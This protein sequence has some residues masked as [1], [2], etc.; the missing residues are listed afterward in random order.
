MQGHKT[1]G[2][3]VVGKAAAEIVKV[4]PQKDTHSAAI[5]RLQ[6]SPDLSN[7]SR[8]SNYLYWLKTIAADRPGLSE[9][10]LIPN[11][12]YQQL[13]RQSLLIA[14]FVSRPQSSVIT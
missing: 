10:S 1:G 6:L 14:F 3:S 2:L 11:E 12:L 4:P 5:S 8:R 13:R 9:F 7:S